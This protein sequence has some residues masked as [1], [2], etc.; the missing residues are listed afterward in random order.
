MLSHT[1]NTVCYYYDYWFYQWSIYIH[2]YNTWYYMNKCWERTKQTH[3]TY[4]QKCKVRNVTKDF[5]D[6]GDNET[7]FHVRKIIFCIHILFSTSD[8]NRANLQHGQN[9]S[10]QC[11]LKTIMRDNPVE[12]RSTRFFWLCIYYYFSHLR[13]N[14]IKTYIE[15]IF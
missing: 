10:K 9:G 5:G 7:W 15:S 6:V 3:I 12:K 8:K 14:W 1:W 13:L 2:S 4:K 11:Q